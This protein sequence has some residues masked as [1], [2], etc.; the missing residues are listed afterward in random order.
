[1]CCENQ[2]AH[3]LL[4]CGHHNAS[5]CMH[6]AILQRIACVLQATAER[7]QRSAEASKSREH[8]L[9]DEIAD[10]QQARWCS[11]FGTLHN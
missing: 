5:R 6:N 2:G 7:A 3:Y 11:F 4:L 8:K 1:V 9:R 10:Q